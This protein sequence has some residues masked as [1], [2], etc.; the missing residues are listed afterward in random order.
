M[1]LADA[2]RA[3][4]TSHEVANSRDTGAG[5]SYAVEGMMN[6]PDG[7]N[8]SV[9]TVWEIRPSDPVPRLVSA[10]PMPGRR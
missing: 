2:L 9:R 7:R 10:Y 1:E 6:S 8:P 5:M 4:A 3:H